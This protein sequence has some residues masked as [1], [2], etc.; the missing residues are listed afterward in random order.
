MVPS[1][2]IV[3]GTAAAGPVIIRSGCPVIHQRKISSFISG[4]YR[5]FCCKNNSISFSY[6]YHPYTTHRSNLWHKINSTTRAIIIV[7]LPKSE[8]FGLGSEEN[9]KGRNGNGF[10]TEIFCE[11]IVFHDPRHNLNALLTSRL[12]PSGKIYAPSR[13]VSQFYIKP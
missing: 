4:K 8:S 12:V 9:G 5:Q 1:R 10:F 2:S 3:H 6:E 11:N 7:I 13:L